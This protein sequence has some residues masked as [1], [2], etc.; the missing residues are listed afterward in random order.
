MREHWRRGQENVVQPDSRVDV[1]RPASDTLK[2]ILE[3]SSV[4]WE[5][6]LEKHLNGEK[7]QHCA[8]GLSCARTTDH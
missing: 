3:F 8:C 6:D 4:E 5:S 7:S 2:R 1:L